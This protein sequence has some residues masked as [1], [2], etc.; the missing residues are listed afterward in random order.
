[1]LI[2][3]TSSLQSLRETAKSYTP[4][5]QLAEY[6]RD[7]MSQ[8]SKSSPVYKLF[9]FT[10]NTMSHHISSTKISGMTHRIHYY[11]THSL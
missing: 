6:M 11:M 5:R 8:E 1:M 3:H 7:E 9:E 10:P 4:G 2:P